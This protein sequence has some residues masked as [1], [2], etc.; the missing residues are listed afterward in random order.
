MGGFDMLRARFGYKPDFTVVF[1]ESFIGANFICNNHIRAFFGQFLAGILD[2][3]IRFS[4]KP[5]YNLT[6]LLIAK[7]C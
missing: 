6:I 2:Y 1:S 4:G 7:R 3:V 5:N